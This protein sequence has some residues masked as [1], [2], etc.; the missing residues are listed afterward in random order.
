M[1][2]FFKHGYSE[3]CSRGW[4]G[5]PY[6][7]VFASRVGWG[8]DLLSIFLVILIYEFYKLELS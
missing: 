6:I 3:N 2:G 8:G 1:Y 4:G 5:G 7:I